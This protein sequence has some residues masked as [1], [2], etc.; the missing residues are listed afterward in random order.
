MFFPATRETLSHVRAAKCLSWYTTV[1]YM[2]DRCHEIYRTSTSKSLNILPPLCASPLKCLSSASV[3]HS[4]RP[5][6]VVYM[7]VTLKTNTLE[8]VSYL[9]NAAMPTCQSNCRY[10]CLL[11]THQ[12][13]C[14][15]NRFPVK[16]FT[17]LSRT[18]V[19][20]LTY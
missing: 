13:S 20:S 7:Y 9:H 18:R 15:S 17:K 3:N 5:P 14:S 12:L 4:T 2:I 8:A 10:L 6:T 19:C 11:S 16:A 1:F